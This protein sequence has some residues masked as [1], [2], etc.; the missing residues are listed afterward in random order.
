VRDACSPT[1]ERIVT[2]ATRGYL[3]I[4]LAALVSHIA[5]LSAGFIWLDH[6]HLEDGLALARNGEFLALFTRGFAGT[7]YYRPLMSVSLSLDA[8]LGGGPLVYHFITLLWHAAA[9]VLASVAAVSLG[10][11]RR[12]AGGAGLI[13]AVHPLT[14]LVANAVAFRSESMVAAAL[15]GLIAL[16]Q[17]GKVWPSALV[18]LAGA[19]TKE[20]ALVLGPLFILVLELFPPSRRRETTARRFQLLGAEAAAIALALMLR[21]SFAPSWRARHPTLSIGDALGTRLASSSKS[22]LAL[23]LPIDSGVCDAFPVTSLTEPSAL[24]GA[25]FLLAVAYLAYR[26]R[27]PALLLLIALVP[28]LQLVP[29]MRWWSPHYVYVPLAFA[30]ML[31]VEAIE[32]WAEGALRWVAPAA[33]ALGGLT[34]LEAGRYQNDERFWARELQLEPH[35]REAH[36]FLGDAA[37]VAGRFDDAVRHYEQALADRPALL[38][39][40]DRAAA[41]QNLGVAQL[42]QRQFDDASRNFREALALNLDEKTRGRLQHNLATAE[43]LSRAR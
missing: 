19:L 17:R 37:Q 6:A 8:A 24:L 38:S 41:L 34:L 3:L 23:L 33:L 32:R 20:T 31:V 27:G 2:D 28:S 5:A 42:Q 16:H 35:C 26:R 11:S 30:A 4:A 10:L 43:L 40:V 22:V 14:S 13:F 9:S 29:V 1:I 36:Y 21:L 15:F 7:G 25:A 39:Y 18:L 12:V